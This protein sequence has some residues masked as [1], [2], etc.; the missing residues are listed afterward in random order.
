MEKPVVIHH[1]THMSLCGRSGAPEA[2]RGRQRCPRVPRTTLGGAVRPTA[3]PAVGLAFA[4]VRPAFFAACIVEAA[5]AEAGSGPAAAGAWTV[6]AAGRAGRARVA[7]GRAGAVGAPFPGLRWRGRA[8]SRTASRGHRRRGQR[9]GQIEHFSQVA[10]GLRN[11]M[12]RGAA[13]TPR[14]RADVRDLRLT[15]LGNRPCVQSS[16]FGILMT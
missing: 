15:T 4:A 10:K 14:E 13:I 8:G 5:I 16:I 9:N 2:A 6:R 12:R 1:K 3:C 11:S 7:S